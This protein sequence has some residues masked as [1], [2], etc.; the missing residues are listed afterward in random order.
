L[1]RI[2]AENSL[3]DAR[4]FEANLTL[5][6]FSEQENLHSWQKSYSCKFSRHTAFPG[7]SCRKSQERKPS[8]LRGLL[9]SWANVSYFDARRR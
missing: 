5:F 8:F 3:S 9:P 2:R 4:S 6:Q 7:V 1:S